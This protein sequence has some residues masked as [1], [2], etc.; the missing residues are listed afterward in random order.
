MNEQ[1]I[2]IRPEPGL[3][4][5]IAAARKAG[6]AI[7]GMPLFQVRPLAWEPPPP[8]EYDALL[9]G[10]GNA[11]RHGGAALEAMREKPVFAVGEATAR[12]ARKASFVVEAVGSGGLQGVL[13]GLS[14]RAVRFLRLAGAERVPLQPPPGILIDTRTVYRS[15]ALPMPRELAKIFGCPAL[16]LLHSAA[17]ARHFASECDRLA[18]PRRLVRLAALGPRIAAAAGEGWGELRSA[19]SAQEGSLLALAGDMCHQPAAD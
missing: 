11:F 10:S 14:G 13:D 9:I 6:L 3:G 7:T 12:A 4:S 17:A 18:I 1:I 15:E 16:V 19:E 5:T 8:C 2:A